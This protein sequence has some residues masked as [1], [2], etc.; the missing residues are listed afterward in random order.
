MTGQERVRARALVDAGAITANVERL[1]GAL[2]DAT[3]LAAVVKAD[4]YG[5]GA[6]TAARAALD[7]GARWLCVATAAEA[8]AL[9]AD[10][11]TDTRV[12]V[13]GALA[14]EELRLALDADADVAVWSAE[15]LAALPDGARAHVKLDTGMGRLGTRDAEEAR[16]L[17]DA[18]AARGVLAGAWTHFATA[19]DPDGDEGFFAEQLERFAGW[20]GAVRDAHPGTLLHAANSAGLL[21]DPAAHFD[22]VRPGVAL[23]GLDPF[24]HDPADHGLR[25]ALRLESYVAAVKPIAPG[26]S[27]GYGR[28]FVA[29]EPTVLATV[30]IGYGDGWRR[31]LTN[32][33]EALVRGVRRPVVGAVSMDN[34]V[35]DLGAGT[36]VEVGDAVVLLGDGLLA[37]EVAATLGTINYE[38]T[39]ALTA[40]VPRTVVGP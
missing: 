3:A 16:A 6:T 21:R 5:H 25:P 12:L 40:R 2:P 26:Q 14:P 11:L 18:A 15:A 22:L 20:A 13:L 37:E 32:R 1:R 19:D 7:G 33:G 36:D 17:A 4:G 8:A 34:L 24:G 38:V 30:P 31:G 35:L 9:R 10:G 28:R 27:T 29:A 23:Y 39:C